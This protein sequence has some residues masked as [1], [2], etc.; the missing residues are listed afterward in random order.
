MLS[1]VVVAS[2]STAVAVPHQTSYPGGRWEPPPASYGEVD[3]H[4]MVTMPDGTQLEAEIGYPADLNTG[5]IASG[6]FPV[7]F[8]HSPYT[9]VPD[10]F[11]VTRGFIFA[12]V[13]PRGTGTS[14]GEIVYGSTDPTADFNDAKTIINWLAALPESNGNVGEIGCS[15]P[16]FYAWGDAAAIGPNSPL[17]GVVLEC[18]GA[19]KGSASHEQELDQGIPSGVV[20]FLTAI[21]ALTGPGGIPRPDCLQAQKNLQA[22][23]L[24]GGD[25]A[26]AGST[27]YSDS[28]DDIPANIVKSGIPA[29]MMTNWGDASPNSALWDY[30]QMQ[31]AYAGRP[32]YAP[33]DPKQKVTPRYQIVMGPQ[34]WGH[35]VGI[36][37]GIAMEWFDTWL[38]KANT[39]M[40]LSKVGI[41]AYEEQTG[42]WVNTGT[43][44]FVSNYTQM[45]LNQGGALTAD[46]PSAGGG[47]DTIAW[48]PP[49]QAGTTLVYQSQ[50]LAA[51]ATL[52]G[53]M[54]ATLYAASSNTNLQFTLSLADVAPDGTS[55]DIFAYRYATILG[56][57]HTLV[58]DLTWTDSQGLMIKPYTADL[59]DD[60]L[61][62]DSTYR[63]DIPMP[64]ILWSLAP[65]H[66]LRLTV[67][68]QVAAS[69]CATLG[70]LYSYACVYT[71]PQ[72][73]T[74]P[75]GV[76]TLSHSSLA[77][78]SIQFPL[79]PYGWFEPVRAGATPT[80]AGTTQPLDWMTDSHPGK[81]N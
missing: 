68:T 71:V 48:G 77:P 3:V 57:Q 50:P 27:F 33:M 42:Q 36:D 5:Q 14:Q 81:T 78:S 37:D 28:E 56:S 7:V 55:V 43:D 72:Q 23:I 1:M 70:F 75:G 31:N 18:L 19:G 24:S 2:N 60:Y 29:L 63:F 51:G 11:F 21:C 6:R 69:T 76:Y 20:N 79:L 74:L 80:S 9:D 65:G 22:N 46:A 30:A 4:T 35:A 38:N 66:S 25:M 17:K 32:V 39:G 58:S 15:F 8:Q 52:A 54:A 10:S 53:P 61:Q 47:T 67:N 64:A 45:F 40:Q 26:Y 62:P 13:R 59:R 16:A 49:S 44:P 41:H 12:N 34:S 73:Q